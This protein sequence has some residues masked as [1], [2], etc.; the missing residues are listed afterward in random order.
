MMN[1][2]TPDRSA[3]ATPVPA[4]ITKI[5]TNS[6][7][8]VSLLGKR[9]LGAEVV[10]GGAVVSFFSAYD[11]VREERHLQVNTETSLAHLQNH[12]QRNSKQDKSS[13]QVY[14]EQDGP[15]KVAPAI[16]NRRG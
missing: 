5:F 16:H 2:H 8:E 11:A 13:H 4:R 10:A 6:A 3:E 15:H 12:R 1:I 7:F 14:I 9:L